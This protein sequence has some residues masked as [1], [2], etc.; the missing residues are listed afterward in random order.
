MVQLNRP[1]TVT[2]YRRSEAQVQVMMFIETTRAV[3]GLMK[4]ERRG[5]RQRI[6][7][8]RNTELDLHTRFNDDQ[9]TGVSK[10][11]ITI[12]AHWSKASQLREAAAAPGSRD[13]TSEE[14]NGYQ[15]TRRKRRPPKKFSYDNLGS[16]SCYNVQIVGNNHYPH[17]ASSGMTAVTPWSSTPLCYPQPSYVCDYL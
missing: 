4:A 9:E 15:F 7:Q 5:A 14:E 2:A 17:F 1:I 13:R 6:Y 12:P 10:S 16:P 8:D 11:P 3:T